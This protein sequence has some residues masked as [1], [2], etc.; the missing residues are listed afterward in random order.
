MKTF[1]CGFLFF[2]TDFGWEVELCFQGTIWMKWTGFP[3]QCDLPIPV[4]VF[5][6]L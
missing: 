4:D 3:E 2:V 6:Y 1:V 5:L